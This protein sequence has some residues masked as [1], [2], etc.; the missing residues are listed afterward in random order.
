MAGKQKLPG[1]SLLEY[2]GN[3]FSKSFPQTFLYTI[4]KIIN[5]NLKI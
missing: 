5:Q 3:R 2:E 4:I 1:K